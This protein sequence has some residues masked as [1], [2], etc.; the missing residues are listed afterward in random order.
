MFYQDL[1]YFSDSSYIF[2]YSPSKDENVIQIDNYNIFCY[3]VLEDV[4]HYH[5][6]Y[7]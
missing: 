5:L 7:G 2:F 3:E 1:K 6:E 4:I